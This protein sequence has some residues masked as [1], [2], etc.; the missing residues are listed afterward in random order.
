MTTG[1]RGLHVV[2]P[3]DASV[4]FDEVRELARAVA[5][6]LAE[7][8][9]DRF[10]VEQRKAKRG[11]RVFVDTQRNAYA[12]TSVAPY[13]LR[14]RPG[15]PVAAPLDWDELDPGFDPRRI[16]AANVFRRL[17]QKDDPWREIDAAASSAAEARDAFAG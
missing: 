1:S 11:D 13:A 3:L 7:E 12:Q 5:D 4:G 8:D 15:A 17:G 14:A 6:R 2:A 16:T 9:P 10:T